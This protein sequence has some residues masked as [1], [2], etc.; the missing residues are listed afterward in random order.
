LQLDF[1]HHD[2]PAETK[3]YQSSRIFRPSTPLQSVRCRRD[4]QRRRRMPNFAKLFLSWLLKAGQ[5]IAT[6]T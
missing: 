2:G 1:Q 6:G 5:Q 4:L 3:A